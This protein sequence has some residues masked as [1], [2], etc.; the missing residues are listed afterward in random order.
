[1]TDNR[2]I[3]DPKLGPQEAFYPPSGW[4]E[5]KFDPAAPPLDQQEIA[6]QHDALR[7]GLAAASKELKAIASEAAA[8][9]TETAGAAELAVDQAVRLNNAREKLRAAIAQL[10]DTAR[11]AALAPELRPLAAAVREVADRQL[12]LAEDA[13]RTAE[14]DDATARK[15]A[16]TAAGTHLAEADTKLTDVL[17]RNARLGAG[18]ARSR[19]SARSP[20]TRPRSPT[21]R[22]ALRTGSSGSGNCSHD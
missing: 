21:R 10:H 1:M 2:A 14:T 3:V 4:C 18:A 15:D 6:S 5:L 8:L 22:P 17:N 9:R 7:E 13:L 16:F 20:R 11:N 19:S 12:K